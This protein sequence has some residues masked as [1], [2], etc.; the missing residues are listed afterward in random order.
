MNENRSSN[1]GQKYKGAWAMILS[2]VLIAAALFAVLCLSGC[3]REQT[4]SGFDPD[5]SEL[6]GK[7]VGVVKAWNADYLLTECSEVNLLRYDAL[8]ELVIALRFGAVD[9]AVMDYVTAN[10]V[11]HSVEGLRISGTTVCEDGL[12]FLGNVGYSKEILEELDEWIENEWNGSPE[13]A[14]LLERVSGEDEYVFKEVEVPESDRV[15]DIMYDGAGYP[16]EYIDS[17]GKVKG[18]EVEPLNYFAI[19]KG[20]TI[21]WIE[22]EENSMLASAENADALLLLLANSEVFRSALNARG[23]P[24]WLSKPFLES[25]LVTVEADDPSKMK[26]VK[27]L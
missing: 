14:D 5:I 16:Y 27:S 20:Y 25:R 23:E 15:I 10:Y 11:R 18:I 13:Q 19:A 17:D 26:V 12:T 4:I 7:K 24:F 22:G 2:L 6:Q 3:T 8:S 1:Y 9:A 21:N